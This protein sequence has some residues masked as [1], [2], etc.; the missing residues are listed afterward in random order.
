MKKIK[1]VSYWLEIR[2]DDDSIEHEHESLVKIKNAIYRHVDN[3][4]SCQIKTEVVS[5]CEYCGRN[6]T[7]DSDKYNACCEQDEM[8]QEK[9]LRLN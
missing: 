7:E 6:W 3:I 5:V 8:D 1:V 9:R 4:D 2:S